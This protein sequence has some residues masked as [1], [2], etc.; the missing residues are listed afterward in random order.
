MATVGVNWPVGMVPTD[1]RQLNESVF[2]SQDVL[3]DATLGAHR[4]SWL[5]GARNMAVICV[6]G[7]FCLATETS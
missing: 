6:S 3:I 4:T 1:H 5:K 2:Q 7:T